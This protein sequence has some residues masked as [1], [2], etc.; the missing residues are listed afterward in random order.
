MVRSALVAGTLKGSGAFVASL[1]L[2]LQAVQADYSDDEVH[3]AVFTDM[4]GENAEVEGPGAHIAASMAIDDFGG[5]VNGVDIRS[6]AYHHGGSRPDAV[7]AVTGVL[8]ENPDLI[9]GMVGFGIADGVQPQ[10]GEDAVLMNTG[11]VSFS[12]AWSAC[13]PS[14]FVWA[15]GLYS[16]TQVMRADI[17]AGLG[18]NPI[19]TVYGGQRQTL[20]RSIYEQ[21][22]MQS[23][24]DLFGHVFITDI[25]SMGL[26]ASQGMSLMT[27][28]YWNRDDASREFA[29]RFRA[30]HG[31]PPTYV[32]AAVYSGVTNY[33]E[34]V[35]ESGTDDP[36][37][38]GETMQEQD[39]S[40]FYARN[41]ELRSDGQLMQDLY[42]MRVRDSADV[43]SQW[44][45]YEYVSTL[46]GEDMYPP[47]STDCP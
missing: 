17:S 31:T 45:Y 7:D 38:V 32:Q 11:S 26:Y 43:T 27:P 44:D 42:V 12:G 22:L 21:G 10:V 15:P 20:I 46:S 33:L 13:D 41:G 47:V 3:V 2:G 16:L 29:E 6:R 35:A 28:F 34:A 1:L 4:H 14:A 24:S 39:V 18:G 37:Q 9:I 8:E 36:V 30:R 25:R 40:D 5:E 19:F 23:G